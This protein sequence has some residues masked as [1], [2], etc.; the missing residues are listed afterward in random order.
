M[1]ALKTLRGIC[2]VTTF[3]ALL[4]GAAYLIGGQLNGGHDAD[5]EPR[6]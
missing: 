5:F 4:I 1:Y 6:Q 2:Y 3:A